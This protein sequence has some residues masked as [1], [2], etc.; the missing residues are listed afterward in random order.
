MRMERIQN[1]D[2]IITGLKQLKTKAIHVGEIFMFV[3]II[4]GFE[5]LKADV[6]K[7]IELD[8]DLKLT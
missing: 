8:E 7:A 5:S 1:L 6:V 3:G 2:E 4:Q